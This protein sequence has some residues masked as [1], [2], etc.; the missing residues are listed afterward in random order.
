MQ[1]IPTTAVCA[2]GITIEV[3]LRK[4]GLC[5]LQFKLYLDTQS[6]LNSCLLDTFFVVASDLGKYPKP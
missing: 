6:L 2:R 1:G 3:I 5:D 4:H